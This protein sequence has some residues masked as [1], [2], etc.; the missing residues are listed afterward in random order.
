MTPKISAIIV[1]YNAGSFLQDC[2][3]S[4]LNC[5]MTVEVIVVDNHSTDGSLEA[6]LELPDVRV[7][8]NPA[9]RGFAVACNMGLGIANSDYLL[10]LNPDCS[11]PSDT[12][13]KLLEPMR[14]DGKAGMAGGLLL[15]PDG[16][17]QSGGRRN[18]PT[19]WRAFVRAFGLNRLA[20]FWPSLFADLNQISQPLP[21]RPVE[22]E[23]ISGACMLV[24]HE[25]I[26]Q[27]GIWDEGYFLHC[28][29]LDWCLRFRQHGWK[30]LFVPSAPV[31]HAAGTC[32]R[33]RP[34]FVEWHK[35]RGMLRF[36][37]KFFKKQYPGLLWWLVV[38]GIWL[39]FVSVSMYFVA[40]LALAR[41]GIT[42]A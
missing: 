13:L 20:K 10:F 32:S 27:V 6:I 38:L 1:N 3:V 7:I 19:P 5:P 14:A 4:L 23:A 37:K 31:I 41:L 9:N 29:D 28:E 26:E 33:S 2:V 22:V 40:K 12:L 24:K 18:T 25:A 21:D 34:L 42:R 11:L 16:S 39:R 17:E 8:R 30:I 36:Y 35:H 15:N